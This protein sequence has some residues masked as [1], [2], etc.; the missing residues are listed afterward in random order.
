[1][2][3]QPL[4]LHADLS[5]YR[6]QVEELY[7]AY[8]SGNREAFQLVRH[9]HPQFWRLPDAAFR[10]V[11]VTP[12]DA[13][14]VVAQYYAFHHW[15]ELAAWVAAVT[16]P[17]SP[18]AR[19]EAAVDA[20]VA[21]AINT[22]QELLANDTALITARSM[23]PHHA[24]LL[25][26]T[27]TN[28]VEGYRQRYPPNAIEVLQFL[29][30]A[31]ADVNAQAGM[32]GGGSTTLGL[33]A[34]SIHPAKAG[35][36]IPLLDILLKAGALI[37]Q[38]A[39]AGNSQYAINGCLHNG[40][41]EAA[42]YLMRHGAWLDLEGA[43]GVGRLDV[44]KTFFQKEGGLR[45]AATTRQ[46]NEGFMW[47]AE[48]GHTAVID[49][50]LS[51]GLDIDV[52]VNGMYGL[53]WALVGGHADTIRL[54]VARGASLEKRNMYGG[55][56]IGCAV[57]ALCNSS[58]VYRWPEITVD[59]FMIIKE[60]LQAGAPIDEGML[61]WL[62]GSDEVPNPVR[63]PLDNLFRQYGATT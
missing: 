54:L 46:M 24:T 16:Q 1:M 22:L 61:G 60:L 43:A 30:A 53:H 44:V 27:G 28:G 55:N 23:R 9:T 52:E 56:A 8:Q 12:T 36:L 11:S 45:D 7:A 29:L 50:L 32:Y 33:V 57:W 49:Y 4:P 35:I 2:Y 15:D 39:A 26:Y 48:F 25:H 41:P 21:G 6:Q 17:G 42:D 59:Y 38:P 13:E 51:Q 3:L 10:H 18:A 19:F 62:A 5:Q 20:V 14:T 34:T 63:E 58:E 40:R 47:A 37:D 31:G